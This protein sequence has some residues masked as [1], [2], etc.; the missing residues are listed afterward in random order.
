MSLPGLSSTSLGV[1]VLVTFVN[2]SGFLTGS[3]KA[4]VF[5]VLVNWVADPV[6]SWV[7]SDSLVLWVDQDNFVVFVGRILVNPVRVQDS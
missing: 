6:V 2:T 7:S 1:V 5:T 4:S 3:S